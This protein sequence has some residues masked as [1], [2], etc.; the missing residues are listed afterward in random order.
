LVG[1]DNHLAGYT[2]TRH[3][4]KVGARRIVFAARLNSA[5]TVTARIAGYHEA[6]HAHGHKPP[7]SSVYRG[8]FADTSF[9]EAMLKETSLD[10]IVCAND[11]T[12]ATV[13]K[14]LLKL[15]VKVPDEVRIVGIDDVGY[16][17]FLPVPLT[18]LHQN[19]AEMGVVA[20]STMLER[21]HFPSTT[22]REILAPCELIVRESCGSQLAR[23]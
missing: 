4:L 22:P 14:S 16:A 6:L 9:I 8:D 23:K 11:V 17:K 2:M 21:V 13:M 20:I 5:S 12:A 19:C 10:A 1:I 7:S 18:T 15:G 3:L